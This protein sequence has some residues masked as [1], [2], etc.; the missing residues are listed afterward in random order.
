MDHKEFQVQLGNV[1]VQEQ[2]AAP[3]LLE[4]QAQLEFQVVRD[5]LVTLEV[6][7]S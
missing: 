3:E 5:H 6:A 1:E 2:Q 7:D 4:G